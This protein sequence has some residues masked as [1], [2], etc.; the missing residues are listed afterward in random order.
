MVGREGGQPVLQPV[1]ADVSS[2]LQLCH[3]ISKDT[4]MSGK[5]GIRY[6]LIE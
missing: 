2:S 3:T 5:D 1:S 4:I 6:E